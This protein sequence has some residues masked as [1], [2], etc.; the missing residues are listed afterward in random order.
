MSNK[1][2]IDVANA[3]KAGPILFSA[4][5]VRA[6]LDGTKTQTRRIMKVQP[7]D[8][9]YQLCTLVS[10]TAREDIDGSHHWAKPGLDM[11]Q[12]YFRSPYGYNGDR[13]WVRESSQPIMHESLGASPEHDQYDYKTGKGY[14]VNYPATDGVEEF[15]DLSVDRFSSRIT[16][17]IHMPRWA[18]RITLEITEVRVQRLQYI[19]DYDATAEGVC[20]N[21]ISCEHSSSHRDMFRTLWE[22]INGPESWD[23]NPWV[24][25]ISFDLLDGVRHHA[26][27]EVR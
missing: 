21:G 15:Y 20:E 12:P 7:P 22:S 16:P 26:F 8:E 3:T 13:L 9:N 24:W 23:A 27:P 25:A 18:S 11:K 10:S 1:T 19:S 5:M 2:G 6:L 4:P 17:S 14:A